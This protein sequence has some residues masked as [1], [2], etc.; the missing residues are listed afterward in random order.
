MDHDRRP[1]A[2]RSCYRDRPQSGVHADQEEVGVLGSRKVH[3]RARY[4]DGVGRLPTLLRRLRPIDSP[5]DHLG[6]PDE[7]EEEARCVRHLL[8]RC[9]VSIRPV[10]VSRNVLSG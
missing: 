7:L 4:R 1:G 5:E 6:P 3:R 10:L 8:T 9:T 2:V